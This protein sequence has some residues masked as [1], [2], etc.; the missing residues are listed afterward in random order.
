MENRKIVLKKDLRVAFDKLGIKKG[1]CV[2]VHASLKSMGF[3]CGGAQ[4][5]IEE[6]LEAV[7]ESGTIMMPAQSWKNLDPETGVHWE[8]PEEWWPMIRDYW[9]AY[10]KDITP[11]DKM[12]LIAEMFRK[13]KGSKRSCHPARSF[14]AN[15]AH[16]EYLVE[17]HSLTDIFGE[18]SPLGKLY[19]LAGKVLLIGTGY[20]K[21]TSIHLAD[22]RANYPNK[23]NIKENSAVMLGGEREWISYE[24]LAVD[25]ADF[26][27]IGEAFEVKHKVQ[28]V[29]IGNAVVTCMKQREL[30][31]FAVKWIGN[32]RK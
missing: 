21:N 23:K 16:S 18:T 28:K 15:G 8:E 30:V 32:H 29:N 4:I 3:V 11:T 20:D 25:G 27:Q 13:W 19:Q 6:L 22:E 7:G 1:D 10:D 5:I 24:T 31:D 9:P 17:N 12:G 26:N 2:I 14:A